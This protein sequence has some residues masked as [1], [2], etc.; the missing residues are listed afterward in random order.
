MKKTAM[1]LIPSRLL[2]LL[3]LPWALACC[4]QTDPYVRPG[5]WHALGANSANLRAMV[6]DQNDLYSGRGAAYSPGDQAAAA[7]LRL[8]MDQVKQLPD[9][10]LTDVKVG[11]SSSGPQSPSGA[12]AAAPVTGAA[13]ASVP[14]TQ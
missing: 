2:P 12:N 4:T 9:S 7:V 10:A 6:A 3:L 8:R 11:D 14:V 1:R 13:A 5:E